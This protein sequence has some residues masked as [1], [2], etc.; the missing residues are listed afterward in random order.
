MILDVFLHFFRM[1]FQGYRH[2]LKDEEVWDLR[3]RDKVKPLLKT[4][5]KDWLRSAK[6]TQDTDTST[7]CNTNNM[8]YGSMDATTSQE[9]SE[10]H[11]NGGLV[12]GNNMYQDQ[13]HDDVS[14]TALLIAKEQKDQ[15]QKRKAQPKSDQHGFDSWKKDSDLTKTL[16]KSFGVYYSL[17]G[18]YEL[19][20]VILTFVRPLI[21]E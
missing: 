12:V 3:P 20:S 16:W 14:E 21:L 7:Y 11:E 5:Y 10:T 6:K 4:F 17:I 13:N 9:C 18:I 1:L 2:P 15:R 19:V 8:G